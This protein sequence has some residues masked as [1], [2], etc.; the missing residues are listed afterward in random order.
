MSLIIIAALLL[1]IYLEFQPKSNLP[2][3]SITQSAAASDS[4]QLNDYKASFAIYTHNNFRYFYD[5]K[6]H[7]LSADVYIQA[8][9]PNII[10]VK[11]TGL[12]W[13]DFFK[14]LPMKLTLHCL[15]TGTGENYCT[16]QGGELKFYLNGKRDL[17]ILNEKIQKGD[18]LLVTYGFET[19]DQIALQLEQ[20]VDPL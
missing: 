13:G 2:D 3:S 11:K 5:P 19:S 7:N 17:N 8:D 18:K 10:H 9:N 1:L 15:T 6:Y 20:I 12:V 16:G 4:Q 14:T